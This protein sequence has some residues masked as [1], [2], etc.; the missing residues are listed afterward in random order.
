MSEFC[1]YTIPEDKNLNYF[2]ILINV[3]T[4]EVTN[5]SLMFRKVQGESFHFCTLPKDENSGFSK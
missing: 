2:V 5:V 1:F 4:V 3:I